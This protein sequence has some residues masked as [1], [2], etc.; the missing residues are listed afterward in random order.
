M[1]LLLGAHAGNR[2][3]SVDTAFDGVYRRLKR[4][5]AGLVANKALATKRMV[6]FWQVAVHDVQYVGHGLIN[7][8]YVPH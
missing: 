6:M 4:A 5:V 3:N 1:M 2:A 8:R 7:T